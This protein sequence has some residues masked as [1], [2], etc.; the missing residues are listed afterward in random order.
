MKLVIVGS[1]GFIGTELVRQA[2]SHPGITS[3][4]GIS[5]RETPIPPGSVDNKAKLK[6]VIC[7]DFESY[8][9]DVKR[10]IEIANACIWTVPVAPAELNSIPWDETIKICGDYALTAIRTL[11]GVFR[12][13]RENGPGPVRFIYISDHFGPLNRSES[14]KPLNSHGLTDL[15]LLRGEVETQILTIANKSNGAVVSCIATPGVIVGPGGSLPAIPNLPK[16]E[17]CDIAAALLD[18][19]ANG[20]EKNTLS[21]EDM[22]RI[23]QSALR[24][25]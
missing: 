9:S 8:P 24:K 15:A 2:L 12:Y 3:I 19:V 22:V 7:N 25:Q 5:R 6:S 14:A 20:F 1:T 11:A 16:I 18:Q 13:R 10:E 17:L 21:N 23:G 4:V